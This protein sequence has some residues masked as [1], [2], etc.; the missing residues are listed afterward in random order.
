METLHLTVTN[1]CN[2]YDLSRQENA[3]SVCNFCYRQKGDITTDERLIDTIFER[4]KEYGQ[5]KE[6]V[7]TGGD[8][9]TSNHLGYIADKCIENS[10]YS[11]LHTNGLFLNK[12]IDLILDKI[13]CVTLPLDG[14]N[15]EIQDYHR[16]SGFFDI[17]IKNIEQLA[18]ADISLGIN[19]FVSKKNID[20]L[21][22]IANIVSKFEIRYWLI[23][24]FRK[25]NLNAKKS[26]DVYLT[27]IDKFSS[28]IQQIRAE[29][30]NLNI[31]HL[32]SSETSFPPRLWCQ[33]DGKVFTD[34]S[35]T[36]QNIFLGNL[37]ENS[38]D[39]FVTS[40]QEL[41]RN[42]KPKHDE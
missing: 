37:T 18:N 38:L 12:F 42:E 28:L 41:K 30:S 29:F 20:D 31:F 1:E 23:S 35:N 24:Q 4:V 27:D 10:L 19:T 25:I 40:M 11:T 3:P 9:L 6:V 32:T 26:S 8:P 2:A 16:G 17:T 13:S 15:S 14:S 7:L 21:I 22:N 36:T 33:I 39:Y 34:L 5:I